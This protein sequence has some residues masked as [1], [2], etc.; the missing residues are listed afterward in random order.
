MS[1]P[2]SPR[3]RTLRALPTLLRVGAAETVAYRVEF[4]IWMLT[5]TMPLVMLGLWTSVAAEAP[6]AQYGQQKFVAYYVA[7]LIVRNLSG[8]WVAWQINEEVRRGMLSFRLLRPVHPFVTYAAT[9]ISSVPLRSIVAIPFALI[10]LLTGAREL[11]VT[12]PVLLVILALSLLGSWLL[13][14]FAMVLLGA[15]ALFIDKSIA[16]FEAYLGVY[17]VMSGYLIPLELLPG[18]AKAATDWTPFR[19][20]LGFPVN[21]AIGDYSD[22]TAALVDLALQWG[23][24]IAIGGLALTLWRAGIRRYE[25]YGS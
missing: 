10:L 12:D 22:R 8:S 19:F 2:I 11:L 18:W 16:L 15:A 17:G 13:T 20:M 4:V 14:F 6:F 21:L 1:H 3:W 23:W 7:A 5:T 9:H 25:A 24:V